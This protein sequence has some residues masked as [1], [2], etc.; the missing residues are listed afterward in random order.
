MGR[1][2][3]L[4]TAALGGRRQQRALLGW[5]QIGKQAA[6]PCCEAQLLQ[7]VATHG[8]N[9]WLQQLG[10]A[11]QRRHGSAKPRA[12]ARCGSY[13]RLSTPSLDLEHWSRCD[14]AAWTARARLCSNHRRVGFVRPRYRCSYTVSV[15]R[16]A[17]PPPR[18]E[19][20][21]PR[22][23]R[24]SPARVPPVAAAAVFQTDGHGRLHAGHQSCC[25]TTKDGAHPLQSAGC[26]SADLSRLRRISFR[27]FS[28]GRG[29]QP[30]TWRLARSVYR[31]S[32]ASLPCRLPSWRSKPTCRAAADRCARPSTTHSPTPVLSP[33][34]PDLRSPCPTSQAGILGGAAM[35]EFQKMQVGLFGIEA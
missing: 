33:T 21:P 20:A 23:R 3:V 4:S 10:A 18:W 22:R 19:G 29:H 26:G 6:C 35:A 2:G 11:L 17:P 7:R 15:F 25:G 32:Q 14:P 30:W 12:A 24:R 34:Y 1:A 8:L 16:N 27:L 9:V 28:A 13:P 5:L 31:R